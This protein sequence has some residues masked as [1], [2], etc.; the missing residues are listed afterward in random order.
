MKTLKELTKVLSSGYTKSQKINFAKYFFSRKSETLR[1]QPIV[2]SIVA[3]GR[4]TLSCDMCPTHSKI[5]PEDYE[6]TQT[7]DRDISF[8]L[9]KDVIDRFDRAIAVHI[10]GS[11]EPL[12][13]RDLF[14]MI[15]Y[16]SKKKMLVKTISN[17]TV[18]SRDNNIDKI[19][20]SGLEG[21]TV[22]ING[23]C[24]DEFSRMTG[25]AP[26]FY[27]RIYAGVREL[28]R[29]KKSR[30]SKVNVKLSFI[31]DRINARFIDRMIETALTLGADHTFF[32]NFLPAPFKG[33][34]VDERVLFEDDA[35]ALRRSR[36]RLGKSERKRF[37]F[38]PLLKREGTARKC[39]SHFYQMRVDADGNV[40]SC[41]M[42]LLNMGGKGKF[43]DAGS[44]NNEFFR[45][46][47]KKF[48]DTVEPLPE[49]CCTC[50]NNYGVTL[51]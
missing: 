30:G 7:T 27:D 34:S 29:E 33:L 6:H 13:N 10:I 51:Q 25:M 36:D 40:S 44:W 26:D 3:T 48:L 28:I 1:Y 39:E 5:V 45:S 37:T 16:A 2:L 46:M 22:S 23:D 12:L 14:A 17:G 20:S 24:P 42:M 9:F 49:P 11:G 32:C 47:R 21:I 43:Y 15:E 35:A 18:L 41:S 50:V 19:L 31:L 38:P 8:A 4:C